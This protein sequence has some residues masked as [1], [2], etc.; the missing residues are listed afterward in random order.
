MKVNC[1]DSVGKDYKAAL[2]RLGVSAQDLK[3]F[4]AEY[5]EVIKSRG[6]AEGFKAIDRPFLAMQKAIA[7]EKYRAARNALAKMR[8]LDYLDAN[9]SHDPMEGIAGKLA[10]SPTRGPGSN[11]SAMSVSV[12]S[13]SSAL[14]DLSLRLDAAGFSGLHKRFSDDPEF[15][16]DTIRAIWALNHAEETAH[17]PSDALAVAKILKQSDDA[18]HAALKVENPSIGNQADRAFTINHDEAIIRLDGGEEGVDWIA[19]IRPLLNEAKTFAKFYH[20]KEAMPKHYEENVQKLLHSVWR[21]ITTGLSVEKNAGESAAAPR[22]LSGSEAVKHAHEMIL[23]FKGPDEIF[24]YNRS[25]GSGTI[26]NST[27]NTIGSRWKSVG[28]MRVWGPSFRRNLEDVI[29]AQ[30]KKFSGEGHSKIAQSITDRTPEIMDLAGIV[31][32]SNIAPAKGTMA[33]GMHA[34][35]QM[36]NFKLGGGGVTSFIGDPLAH[37]SVMGNIGEPFWR[38]IFAMFT[39]R[40]HG[41]SK[42]EMLIEAKSAGIQLESGATLERIMVDPNRDGKGF[43]AKS[44]SAF[45]RLTGLDW[46]TRNG[47]ISSADRFFSLVHG[48]KGKSFDNLHPL[49]Q[50]DMLASGIDAAHWDLIRTHGEQEWAFKNQKRSALTPEGVDNAPAEAIA[51]LPEVRK[52]LDGVEESRKEKLRKAEITKEKVLGWIDSRLAKITDAIDKARLSGYKSAWIEAVSKAYKAEQDMLAYARKEFDSFKMLDILAAVE[53][54]ADVERMQTRKAPE[55]NTQADYVVLDVG[56]GVQAERVIGTLTQRERNK[57]AALGR[58]IE[59]RRAAVRKLSDKASK[60][61]RDTVLNAGEFAGKYDLKLMDVDARIKRINKAADTQ[62]E[63]IMR[64]S[65]YRAQ[66]KLRAWYYRK[67]SHSMVSGSARVK[68]FVFSGTDAGSF[69]REFRKSLFQFKTFSM[70]FLQQQGMETAYGRA[71]FT[72][73]YNPISMQPAKRIFA[74]KGGELD[75]VSKIIIAAMISGTGMYVAR[76]IQKGRKPVVPDSPEEMFKFALMAMAN[77]G[78]LAYVGDLTQSLLTWEGAYGAVAFAGP[79]AQDVSSAF[80]IIASVPQGDPKWN[81][82]VN[83]LLGHFPNTFYTKAVWER[84]VASN[85]RD[86][87]EP[88]WSERYEQQRRANGAGERLFAN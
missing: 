3:G 53:E 44:I 85:V 83:F 32:G 40:F 80:S 61:E 76:E 86:M 11:E 30:S 57:A 9:Y 77:G 37:A 62:V 70:N 8:I 12:P 22:G 42:A 65:R 6:V 1:P 81:Q 19:A 20:R 15:E 38:S 59:R 68:R 72:G 48:Y 69:S 46:T 73:I 16:R 66:D 17:I 4:A 74:N 55:S 75:Q 64:D 50:K 39:N 60:Q 49:M 18:S 84:A 10:D 7:E 52:Q 88:G 35:I 31:D 43:L 14:N 24:N 79:V 2:Q 29:A 28:I 36:Q 54:G 56:K 33:R 63:E 78:A 23:I 71:D 58:E 13:A 67:A 5:G 45:H 82:A 25:W 41:L 21:H 51:A 47:F 87:V 27:E 34:L 26:M